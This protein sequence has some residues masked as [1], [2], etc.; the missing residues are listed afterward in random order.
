MRYA[1]SVLVEYS[2]IGLGIE[3]VTLKSLAV[4]EDY[5]VNCTRL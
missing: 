5:R 3:R 2:S 4:S 1:R